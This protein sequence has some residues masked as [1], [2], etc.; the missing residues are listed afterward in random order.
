LVETGDL[1]PELIK[2]PGIF[3]DFLVKG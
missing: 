2:T 1:Y 3:V